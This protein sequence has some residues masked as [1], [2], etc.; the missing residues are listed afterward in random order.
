[1]V[2]NVRLAEVVRFSNHPQNRI[3]R[4]NHVDEI[5]D[6]ILSN[7]IEQIP[8]IIVSIKTN[9]IV[10]GHHRQ[11]AIADLMKENKI[12]P[13]LTIGVQ[14]RYLETLED[15][16][17]AIKDYQMHS[18]AWAPNDFFESFKQVNENY[19]RLDSFISSCARLN[20]R[21][22]RVALAIIFG[23]TYSQKKFNDGQLILT[24]DD[25]NEGLENYMQID[26]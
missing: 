20:K 15:E 18:K 10:D 26:K 19:Q 2:E 6:C 22:T 7:G 17:A 9:N 23:K 21:S 3:I 25:I 1:M 5:K 11:V 16:L 8:T 14:W 4:D 24:E 13:N 12:N